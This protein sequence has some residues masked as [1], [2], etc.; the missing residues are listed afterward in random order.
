MKSWTVY[1]HVAPNGKIYVGISSNIKNRWAADGYYYHLSDTIFSRALKRYGWDNFQHIV[2]SEGLTKE[3]ACVMEK[4]LI[5][6]YKACNNSYNITDGGEGFCGKH[7]REHI[8]H[9]ISSRISNSD[10]DYV[11]IDKDYNYIVYKTEREAAEY[12]GGARNSIGHIL[13]QPIGYTFKNH[14]IWKHKKGTPVDIDSIKIQIQ[15]ALKQRQK[16]LSECGKIN[17]KKGRK[18]LRMKIQTMSSEE[19]RKR[20]GVRRSKD[21][22]IQMLG[23]KVL[24]V[25]SDAVEARDKLGISS[26]NILECAKGNRKTAGGYNWKFNKREITYEC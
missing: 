16:R 9:M 12:L 1:K 15:E 25:F 11:V 5:A 21:P 26:S 18:A 19:K 23:N 4:K 2:V 7:S 6:E 17:G 14:Y 8:Q 3:D 13:R 20:F 10:T 22:V 24:C